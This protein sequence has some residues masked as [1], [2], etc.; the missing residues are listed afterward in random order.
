MVSSRDISSDLDDLVEAV[1]G[2]GNDDRHVE[3]VDARVE[4]KY[5]CGDWP[6]AIEVMMLD[7]EV[8][9]V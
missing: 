5:G 2:S 6:A 8:N 3:I 1:C 4:F 9:E 7:E